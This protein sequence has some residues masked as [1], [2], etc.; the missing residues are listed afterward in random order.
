MASYLSSIDQELIRKIAR[1][2][3]IEPNDESTYEI[4]GP[5]NLFTINIKK[6]VMRVNCQSDS[7][8]SGF[9]NVLNT[10]SIIEC[11][12]IITFKGMVYRYTFLE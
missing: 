8:T 5:D 7:L 4:I 1:T 6:S 9:L 3:T 11:Q 12:C 10:Q 2:A